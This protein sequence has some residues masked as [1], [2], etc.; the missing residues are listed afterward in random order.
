[1]ALRRRTPFGFPHHQLRSD[2]D[3]AL[4]GF[5][6]AMYDLIAHFVRI[7]DQIDYSGH[8]SFLLLKSFF[9]RFRL[10]P[11]IKPADGQS[12]GSLLRG[13]RTHRCTV[14]DLSGYAALREDH[15]CPPMI[16]YPPLVHIIGG[17][18]IVASYS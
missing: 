8:V 17:E 15:R 10:A 4:P 12:Q 11:A 13:G 1:M 3:R 5:R 16:H 14:S 7:F 18:H 9:L 2:A 6:D